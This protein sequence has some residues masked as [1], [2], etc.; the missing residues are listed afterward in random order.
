MDLAAIAATA[1]AGGRSGSGLNDAVPVAQLHCLTD[2][3]LRLIASET[4]LLDKLLLKDTVFSD[5]VLD[6]HQAQMPF[7]QQ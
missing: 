7:S 4:S 5:I 3:L 1:D 6:L 2:A